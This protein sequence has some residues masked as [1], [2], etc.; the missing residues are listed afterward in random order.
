[1]MQTSPGRYIFSFKCPKS[2]C[3]VLGYADHCDCCDR[4]RGILYRWMLSGTR[5]STRFGHSTG[6]DTV[7]CLCD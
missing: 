3:E 4:G 2:A 6:M 5:N 7:H 1:M